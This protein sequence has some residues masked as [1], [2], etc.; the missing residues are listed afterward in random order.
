MVDVGHTVLIS[1]LRIANG[2]LNAGLGSA[3]AGIRNEGT[4]TLR[5][6]EIVGNKAEGTEPIVRGG[7]VFNRG[8][9][10]IIDS[11]IRQNDA[12]NTGT[13]CAALGGGIFNNTGSTVVIT[14][15]TILSNTARAVTPCQGAF[16]GR[17]FGGGVGNN[18]NLSVL[19]STVHGNRAAISASSPDCTAAGGGIANALSDG[20][21]DA[22]LTVRHSTIANNTATTAGTTCTP[23]AGGGIGA[24]MPGAGINSLFHTIV[25]GN[26]AQFGADVS[27]QLASSSFNLFAVSAGGSGYSTSDLLDLDPL[28]SHL[29]DNG[30]PTQTMALLPGSPAI[31]AGDNTNAPTWDQ[32]GPGFPRVVN[33]TIDIGAFEV[34]ETPFPVLSH[35]EMARAGVRRAFLSWHAGRFAY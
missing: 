15:S 19:N 31:D 4:L 3:G 1:G 34:Q 13:G 22:A 32:R 14:N 28:L 12:T 20:G 27:L 29:A 35:A 24:G 26:Q 7:G 33:G 8:T 6:V 30:G 23:S 5:L 25:A 16:A 10:T 9:L 2:L 11:T 21:L 18:G 17:V